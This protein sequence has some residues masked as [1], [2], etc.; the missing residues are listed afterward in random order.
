MLARLQPGLGGGGAAV[1]GV[2]VL[3]GLAA[4]RIE[5]HVVVGAE[6]DRERVDLRAGEL[7]EQP[8]ALGDLVLELV[9]LERR[10][11][12]VL[13]AVVADRH[14]ARGELL[15]VVLAHEARLAEPAGDDEEGRFQAA[16]L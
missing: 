14:T 1:A 9:G 15:E 3:V 8:P 13:Q 11:V 2:D 10:P 6:R 16:L 5:H 4:Q 12:V 7:L